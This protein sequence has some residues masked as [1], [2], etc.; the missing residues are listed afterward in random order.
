[1]ESDNNNVTCISSTLTFNGSLENLTLLNSAT[2]F[3]GIGA[4]QVCTP[5]IVPGMIDARQ[6]SSSVFI[7]IF[8]LIKRH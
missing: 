8:V 4:A 3:C 6:E 7:M 1:M 2:L 5:I